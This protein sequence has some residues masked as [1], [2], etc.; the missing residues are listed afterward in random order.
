MFWTAGRPAR[1]PT[2]G[3]PTTPNASGWDSRRPR[4]RAGLSSSG[5]QANPSSSDADA[6]G[7]PG[8]LEWA[9]GSPDTPAVLRADARGPWRRAGGDH[10]RSAGTAAPR[11]VVGVAA[12]AGGGPPRGRGRGGGDLAFLRSGGG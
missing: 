1:R 12:G 7:G 4:P 5:S 2:A 6:G 10:P 8:R 11:A 9:G 3:P